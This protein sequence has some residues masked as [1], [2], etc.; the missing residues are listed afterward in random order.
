MRRELPSGSARADVSLEARLRAGFASEVAA[1]RE[2]IPDIGRVL[3]MARI[4]AINRKRQRIAAI[5]LGSEIAVL[6]TVGSLMAIWW[7]EVASGL[8]AMLPLADGG[9]AS[10][11][12]LAIAAGLAAAGVYW[13]RAVAPRG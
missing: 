11:T 12:G 7:E 5:E 3:L 1:S 6:G 9:L 8:E 4:D 2:G 10:T 13:S